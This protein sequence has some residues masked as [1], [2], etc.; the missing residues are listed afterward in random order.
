MTGG[1]RQPRVKDL[2]VHSAEGLGCFLRNVIEAFGAGERRES[3]VLSGPGALPKLLCSLSR[4]LRM[5]ECGFLILF[6]Q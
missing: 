5:L 1:A 4:C 6:Y 3:S 2:T